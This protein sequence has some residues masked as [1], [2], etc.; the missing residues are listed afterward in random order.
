MFARIVAVLAAVALAPAVAIAQEAPAAAPGPAAAPVAAS[1]P[2]ADP[3]ALEGKIDALAEQLA[4][5]RGDVAA[6][7]RLKLSGYIQAL[8]IWQEAVSYN[9]SAAATPPTAPAGVGFTVA[10]GR[11]KAAYDADWSQYVLQIDVVPTLVGIKEAYVSLKLPYGLALDAGLQLMPF[12]YEVFTRSSADLDTL[13]RSRVT[14]AFLLG[15]YD[16][17]VALRGKV[18][19]VNFK[20]GLFNGNGINSGQVGKDNDQLKDVIGRA[21]VDLGM[22]TAGA[23]GWYGKTINYAR[24][25]DKEYPRTRVA[26]D[27]QLFLDLLPIGGSALKGEYMWGQTTIGTSSNNLGAGGNLPGLTSAAPVPTGSGWYLIGLQNVGPWNQ[28]AV[29]YEQY[30]PDHTVDFVASP[31]TVKVQ[32]ELQVAL[33]TFIGGNMKVSAAWYHPMNGEKGPTA[34]ADP[35]SDSFLAQAQVKF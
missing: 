10:R 12:G 35:K 14:R 29:K 16:L 34:P 9:G 30:R 17:G 26:V 4:E 18:S 25:D 33:H 28:L 6:M 2:A 15:E 24:A 19:V 23:S 20:V 11:F 8:Y 27:A 31:S 5:T 22:V 21:W 3:A 7:K 13:A 1:A 32:E